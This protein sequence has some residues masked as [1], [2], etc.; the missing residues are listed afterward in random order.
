[1]FRGMEDGGSIRPCR[2]HFCSR[3]SIAKSCPA[4]TICNH[5]ALKPE[6]KLPN[7]EK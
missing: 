3:A 5:I 2:R 1:M 4:L 7:E 6:K